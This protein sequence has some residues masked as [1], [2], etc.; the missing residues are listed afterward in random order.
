[1][2]E[3]AAFYVLYRFRVRPE[4][5]TAFKE[6]WCRMTEAIRAQRGGLGS[7]LH[8]SDE[9]WW[10]AYAKWPSRQ[11]WEASRRSATSPAPEA[12]ELMAQ[13][14]LERLPPLPLASEIDLLD[15]G[16]GRDGAPQRT[17]TDRH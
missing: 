2:E 17:P 1:M 12:A 7:R 6:G 15:G 16:S 8:R 10:V 3:N 4:R 5:E 14:I 13:G 9:G 11:A